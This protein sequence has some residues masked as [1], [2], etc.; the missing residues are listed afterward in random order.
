M[1]GLVPTTSH[2]INKDYIEDKFETNKDYMNS[3]Y[4]LWKR[5]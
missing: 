3:D 1:E 5:L 4:L 2:P